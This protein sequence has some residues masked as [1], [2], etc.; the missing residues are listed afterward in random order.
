ML[1]AE[2]ARLREELGAVEASGSPKEARAALRSRL[3]RL[4]RRI[5]PKRKFVSHDGAKVPLSRAPLDVL[6]GAAATA[7][8][9]ADRRAAKLASDGYTRVEEAFRAAAEVAAERAW[10][11]LSAGESGEPWR[12]LLPPTFDPRAAVASAPAPA[13]AV[14]VPGRPGLWVLPARLAP[15]EQARWV[16]ASLRRYVEPAFHRN[17]DIDGSKGHGCEAGLWEREWRAWAAA[18]A[19]EAGGGGDGAAPGP[20]G[21]VAAEFSAL[22]RVTWATIGV[23]YD[24]TRREYDGLP[25]GEDG[26]AR[27]GCG[28]PAGAV[29]PPLEVCEWGVQSA[30]AVGEPVVPEAGIVNLY[31]VAPALGSR[32]AGPNGGEAAPAACGSARAAQRQR[33]SGSGNSMGGHVDDAEAARERPVVSMSVGC[34]AVFLLGGADRS[35]EPTALL[36]R[37]GDV[38]VMAGQARLAVHGVALVVPHTCPEGLFGAATGGG[39]ASAGG[40]RGESLPVASG[41]SVAAVA[42][43][44][45]AEDPLWAPGCP[46]EEAA[47]AA[48]ASCL[49]LNINVRQ[50]Y[51]SAPP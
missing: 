23:R 48:F 34:A 36:L 29:S 46:E 8:E 7:A 22:R 47:F 4:L 40:G 10:A 49:R 2:A 42:P 28:R 17:V 20:A 26:A 32:A 21:A 37:S 5:T 12:D 31:H 19:A 9:E 24:W 33:K 43:S 13:T 16:R 14:A 39:A 50:V 25:R 35:E 3:S 27:R 30:A 51:D 45:A 18:R 41:A 1:G 6:C 38:V 44:V 11:A 15:Q